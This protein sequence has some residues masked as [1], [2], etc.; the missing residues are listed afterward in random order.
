MSLEIGLKVVRLCMNLCNKRDN[1]MLKLII[2]SVDSDKYVGFP[3]IEFNYS[4][5]VTLLETEFSKG[6]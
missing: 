3:D 6:Y 2:G 5:D 1:I 4:F